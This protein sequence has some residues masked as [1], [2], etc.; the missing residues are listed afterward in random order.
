MKKNRTKNKWDRQ[1][2]DRSYEA[3]TTI[4]LYLRAEE[5]EVFE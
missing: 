3:G 5:A 1:R 4:V 2:T